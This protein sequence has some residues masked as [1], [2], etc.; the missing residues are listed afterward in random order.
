[1]NV[2][3]L[4]IFKLLVINEKR[5]ITAAISKFADRFSVT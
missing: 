5:T 2:S 1:L 4:F 3:I